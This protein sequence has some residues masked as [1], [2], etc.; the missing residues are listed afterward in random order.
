MLV[1]DVTNKNSFQRLTE[2]IFELEL[3]CREDPI[4]LLIGNK[5]DLDDQREV[6]KVE[7]IEFAKRHNILYMETSAHSGDEV[8]YAFEVLTSEI[9]FKTE[10]WKPE[11]QN[12]SLSTVKLGEDCLE[13][14]KKETRM[15]QRKRSKRCC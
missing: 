9:L 8:E 5:S 15:Q 7:A 13:W 1:F 4:K 12:R 10:L 2:W 3:Y 14:D 6:T 11:N